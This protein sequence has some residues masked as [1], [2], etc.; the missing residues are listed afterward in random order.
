MSLTAGK[1]I[2]IINNVTTSKDSTGK[3]RLFSWLVS[4]FVLIALIVLG[5]YAWLWWLTANASVSTHGTVDLGPGNI[6]IPSTRREPTAN[7]SALTQSVIQHWADQDFSDWQLEGKVDMVRVLIGKLAAKRDIEAVNDYILAAHVRGTV[8]STS[9]FH[10]GGDYDFT[11]AGLCLLLYTF[12]DSP[13]LLY[14]DTVE[15]IVNVLMTEQGGT[16][17]EFTPR[18][19]GLPLRDTENHILMTE[20]SRYLKNRWLQQHGNEDAQFDNATNGLEHFLL[21]DLARMERAGFHEYNSRP[22]IGY[23]LTALLNL[24][25]FAAEPVSEAATRILDRANWEY[26][27]GSLQL[28]RFPP[29]RRQPAHAPDTDLDGDY[30]TAMIKSWLSLSHKTVSPMEIRSGLHHAIWVPFTSYRLPDET[31]EWLVKKPT[32]YFVQIGHG[33]DGSPEIYSGAEHFLISAGGVA[34]DQFKQAVARPTTLMLNDNKLELKDLL[35]ITGSGDDYRRWNNTGV[36]KQFAVGARLIVPNTWQ[37]TVTQGP[38]ALYL[39][40]GVAIVSY[41]APTVAL[42]YVLPPGEPV[43]QLEQLMANNNTETVQ[44]QFTNIANEVIQFDI[45]VATHDWVITNVSNKPPLNRNILS[46][47]LMSGQIGAD[48]IQTGPN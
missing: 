26:A 41:A 8:G 1:V 46:W 3:N 18:I 14:P 34:R 33:H 6:E 32:N 21:D 48:Q 11:L 39:Q 4:A 36:Y 2:G 24:Q 30:H 7:Q 16:P 15:H 40:S 13:E 31:A 35:Q 20:G 17:I 38:W 28:R 12:G 43:S 37:P 44:H 19:L 27:L 25:S 45:N 42:F 9:Y 10:P 29:F 22:Y 23:T 47:S 5:L